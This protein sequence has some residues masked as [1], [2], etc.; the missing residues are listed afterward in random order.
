MSIYYLCSLTMS[1]RN[2]LKSIGD[3]GRLFNCSGAKF[4]SPNGRLTDD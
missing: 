1:I 2:L 3:I 4:G